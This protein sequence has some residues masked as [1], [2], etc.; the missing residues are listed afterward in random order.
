MPRRVVDFSPEDLD[1]LAGAAWGAAARN[2]LAR[3][4]PVTGSI[5]G[6]RIR[7]NPDGSIEDLGPVENS[8]R[9]RKS[10]V[11]RKYVKRAGSAA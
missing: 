7:Y 8:E 6:R 9:H 3:G 4:H 10:K 5:D 11:L 2:A 1:K